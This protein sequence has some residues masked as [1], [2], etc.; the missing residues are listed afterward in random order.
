M[1][2][3]PSGSGVKEISHNWLWFFWLGVVLI[4]LGTTALGA[5]WMVA[6]TSALVFGWLLIFSGVSEALAAIWARHWRAFFLHL[7]TSLLYVLVGVLIIG[8]PVATAA[9]LTLLLAA[10]FLTRGLFRVI[11]AAT[12]RY[13]NWGWAAF[14][15]VVT[16]I[17]GVLIWRHWPA[18][19]LWVIGTFVGIDM[20][21]RGWAWVMFA[22]GARKVA[23]AVAVRAQ[24]V[25]D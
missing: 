4:V 23:H 6:I 10:L 3:K 14:D 25:V 20:I 13:P 17:L 7:L 24:T 1:Q 8:N 2:Q 12:L 16:L 19:A 11:S 21:F 9:G 18:S 22:F 5:T 15:G